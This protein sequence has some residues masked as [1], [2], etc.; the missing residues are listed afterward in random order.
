MNRISR[1]DSKA[2]IGSDGLPLKTAWASHYHYVMCLEVPANAIGQEKQMGQRA[3][4]E[5][6]TKVCPFL[7]T[8]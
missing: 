7:Q 6:E 8:I 2:G 3:F 1:D 5:K 4:E